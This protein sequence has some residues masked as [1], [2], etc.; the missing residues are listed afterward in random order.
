MGWTE[1]GKTALGERS[2]IFVV[3]WDNNA[4]QECVKF[5]MDRGDET[6]YITQ[7]QNVKEMKE[8]LNH[9]DPDEVNEQIEELLEFRRFCKKKLEE[10]SSDKKIHG[11]MDEE[12]KGENTR[13]FMQRLQMLCGDMP[14]RQFAWILGLNEGT[15]F[16]LMH[17]Q[18]T[19]GGHVFKRIA[20]KTGM[21]ADWLM[22]RK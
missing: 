19:P 10:W 17:G 12:E 2:Y 6:E 5:Y 21:S 4:K 8:F 20:D 22:G 14:T 1:E 7:F 11:A 18:R 16:N 3:H 9:A 13:V 15:M